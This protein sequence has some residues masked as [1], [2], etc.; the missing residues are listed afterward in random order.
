MLDESIIKKHKLSTLEREKFESLGK[1]D[2]RESDVNSISIKTLKCNK[3][4]KLQKKERGS[5]K[6]KTFRC[7]QCIW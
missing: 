4:I 7:F 5:N 6:I 1:M 3:I 2:G